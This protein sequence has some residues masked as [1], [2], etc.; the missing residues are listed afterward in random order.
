MSKSRELVVSEQ[1]PLIN[2]TDANTIPNY[3]DDLSAAIQ[4]NATFQAYDNAIKILCD[5]LNDTDVE[6]LYTWDIEVA[7]QY[8]RRTNHTYSVV[9][10]LLKVIRELM[11]LAGCCIDE[12]VLDAQLQAKSLLSE[13]SS[14]LFTLQDLDDI[15]HT[16]FEQTHAD[17]SW[18]EMND[19]S[20]MIII[21]Y[22][23]WL[24]YTKKEIT[25]MKKTDYHRETEAFVIDST[26]E[27]KIRHLDN[28]S[29]MTTYFNKYTDS[30]GYYFYNEFHKDRFIRYQDSDSFIKT[31]Y[32]S[33][34]TT[35]PVVE[36]YCRKIGRN[37]GITPDEILTAGRLSRMYVWDIINQEPIKMKNANKLSELLGI[38]PVKRAT[39]ACEIGTLI[40]IYP[41]YKSTREKLQK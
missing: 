27:K 40:S 2:E 20:T 23:L 18:Y 26:T 5:L 22:L 31:V 7:K 37:F 14:H 36:N 13:Y 21:C 16:N 32:S 25:D 15:M 8:V 17:Y 38:K 30:I 12:S 3:Y 6:P 4:S 1:Y 33:K 29:F 9:V 34:A 11:H 28:Y 41:S 10:Y 24:G 19:W 35:L 39:K